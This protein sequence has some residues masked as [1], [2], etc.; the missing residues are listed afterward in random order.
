VCGGG[1]VLWGGC[2]GGGGFGVWV[3]GSGGGLVQRGIVIIELAGTSFL[4]KKKKVLAGRALFDYSTE[5][6][7]RMEKGAIFRGLF[8]CVFTSSI[9]PVPHKKYQV[10]GK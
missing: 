7:W 1:V 2:G 3:L 9:L 5:L 4:L 6:A 8:R 10:R